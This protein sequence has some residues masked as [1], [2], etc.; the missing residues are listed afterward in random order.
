[1]IRLEKVT[2]YYGPTLAVNDFSLEVPEGQ[3]TVLIGPSGCGK[4][5]TLRMINRLIEPTSGHIYINERDTAAFRPEQLR[6][7]ASFPI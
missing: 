3:V 1:M 4:T 6:M 2:K 5:T 7:S